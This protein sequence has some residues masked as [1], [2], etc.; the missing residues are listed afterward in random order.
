MLL[1]LFPGAA[2][3]EPRR[4]RGVA[5]R[6][7]AEGRAREGRPFPTNHL[8]SIAGPASGRPAH[9]LAQCLS[10]GAKQSAGPFHPEPPLPRELAATP[11]PVPLAHV[12]SPRNPSA[13][14]RPRPGPRASFAAPSGPLWWLFHLEPVWSCTA[15]FG[16]NSGRAHPGP[17]T[18]ARGR[19]GLAS[20]AARPALVDIPARVRPPFRKYQRSS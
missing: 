11:Y 17:P 16:P 19:A 3:P 1:S 9:R 7:T 2:G 10:A 6:A 18:L 8:E 15:P 13:G 5:C 12:S 4:L 20:R 14:T